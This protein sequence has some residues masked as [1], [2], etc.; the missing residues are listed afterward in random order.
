MHE[1]KLTFRKDIHELLDWCNE[2][3]HGKWTSTIHQEAMKWDLEA[4]S[5]HYRDWGKRTDVRSD[6]TKGWSTDRFSEYEIFY[7]DDELEAVMFKLII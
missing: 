6:G 7:F 5:F 2:N 3:C 4:K 1:V